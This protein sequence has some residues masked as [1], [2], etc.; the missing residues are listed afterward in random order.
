MPYLQKDSG[1]KIVSKYIRTF[2]IGESKLEEMIMDLV[3]KQEDVTI[4]TYAKMGEVT[5]RLTCKCPL[6]EEGFDKICPFEDE[7]VK[8][9]GSYVYS[10]EN[11]NLE[12]VVT[13][14]L[15]ENNLTIAIAES[16][17]ERVDL[18]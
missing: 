8:R 13:K 15:L 6:S 18:F 1:Y 17:T 3:D 5:V 10:T 2:G 16:C 4:A 12:K 11:E 14:M 7:I 9:L